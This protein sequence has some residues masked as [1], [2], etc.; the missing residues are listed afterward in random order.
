MLTHCRLSSLANNVSTVY[1]AITLIAIYIANVNVTVAANIVIT[2][3]I[4][5]C[6]VALIAIGITDIAITVTTIVVADV[7][8]VAVGAADVA[9]TVAAVVVTHSL[10]RL[11]LSSVIASVITFSCFKCARH[12]HYSAEQHDRY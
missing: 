7:A 12:H 9:V 8:L 11:L 5:D 10:R 1:I 6:D 4:I 3:V 2:V